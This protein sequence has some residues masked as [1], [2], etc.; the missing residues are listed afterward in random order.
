VI[1]RTE[2]RGCG[3][4]RGPAARRVRATGEQ[5]IAFEGGGDVKKVEVD[6]KGVTNQ[7]GTKW[8]HGLIWRGL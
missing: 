6:G 2:R 8:L 1:S 5:R 3:A 4:A 7:G